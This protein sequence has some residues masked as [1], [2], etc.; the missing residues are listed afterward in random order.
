MRPLTRAVTI[1]AAALACAGCSLHNAQN[2]LDASGPQ[3]SRIA[4]LWWLMLP[5]AAV[6]WV[7]VIAVMLWGAGRKRSVRE[8]METRGGI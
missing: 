2:A 7:I 8:V 5:I 4:G 6:V 3:S 1:A